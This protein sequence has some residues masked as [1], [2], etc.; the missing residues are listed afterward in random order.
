MSI[1]ILNWFKDKVA[2]KPEM[3]IPC[4]EGLSYYNYQK[5]GAQWLASKKAAL[6]ADAPGTGKTITAIAAINSD[7]KIRK[8][9]IICP[10]TLKL[11]WRNELRTWLVDQER[12]IQIVTPMD[13]AEEDSDIVIINY[14]LLEKHRW[15]IDRFTWDLVICDE[16]HYV[17]ESTDE[18][19]YRIIR[20]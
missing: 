19:V 7:P 2:P 10:A 17:K 3:I 15:S 8:I 18:K 14:D 5:V 13:C 9:L 16:A 4:P 20:N 6:L 12:R 1:A 11:N